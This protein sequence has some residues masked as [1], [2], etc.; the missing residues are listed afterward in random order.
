MCERACAVV[1]CQLHVT[2]NV[3]ITAEIKET[4]VNIHY[5]I[6]YAAFI[7]QFLIVVVF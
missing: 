2:N 5:T 3:I 6:P 1:D 7:K 4:F